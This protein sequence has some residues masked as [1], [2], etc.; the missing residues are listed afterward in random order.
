MIKQ[1]V[2]SGNAPQAIGPYSQAVIYN[3]IAYC[4]GQ[5]PLDPATGESFAYELSGG[6]A[7]LQSREK[8]VYQHTIYEITVRK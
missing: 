4:S 3:G 8:S 2:E 6:T 1:I 7:T 5:I